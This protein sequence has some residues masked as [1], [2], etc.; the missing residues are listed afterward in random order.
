MPHAQPYLT[1][2]ALRLDTDSGSLVYSGDTGP[3]K[4]L[5][6]L[7]QGCDVLIHM[8]ANIRGSVDNVAT[9]AGERPGIF[10]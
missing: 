6:K 7:V 10:R 1:C 4:A 9:R 3:S 5:E 8:C 2:L